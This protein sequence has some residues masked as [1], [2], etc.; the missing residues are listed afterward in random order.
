MAVV[1]TVMAQ[2]VRRNC[3]EPKCSAIAGHFL[4][5][6]AWTRADRAA[7]RVRPVNRL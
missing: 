4:L 2:S 6:R 7:L 5:A 1:N 3:R